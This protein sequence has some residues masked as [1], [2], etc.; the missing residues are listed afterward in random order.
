[1]RFTRTLFPFALLTG[2]FASNV[3]DLVPDTFDDVIGKGRPGL[4]EL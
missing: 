4:V 3:L 2:A 1:M